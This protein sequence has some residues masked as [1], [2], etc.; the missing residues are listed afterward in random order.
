MLGKEEVDVVYC[1]RK[2]RNEYGKTIRKDYESGKLKEKRSNMTQWD[3][4][5]DG[6]CNTLTTVLKDNYILEVGDTDVF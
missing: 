2:V 5:E 4:R 1:L 3:I 6:I